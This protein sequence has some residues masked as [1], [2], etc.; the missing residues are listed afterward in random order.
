MQ[1]G[2]KNVIKP[3]KTKFKHGDKDF[4]VIVK[5]KKQKKRDK[6]MYKLQREEKEYVV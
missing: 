4:E 2:G 3:Q 1:T 5:N 6:V